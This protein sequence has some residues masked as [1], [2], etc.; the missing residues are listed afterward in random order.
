MSY[1]TDTIF[2]LI[3][4]V[5]CSQDISEI[6]DYIAENATDY[7]CEDLTYFNNSLNVLRQIYVQ[8]VT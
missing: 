3:E 4:S 8:K 7:S 6:S 5:S 1:S 2:D